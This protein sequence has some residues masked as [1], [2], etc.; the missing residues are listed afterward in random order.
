MNSRVAVLGMDVDRGNGL[1]KM[2]SFCWVVFAMVAPL[3]RQLQ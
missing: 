2:K 3:V 1:S